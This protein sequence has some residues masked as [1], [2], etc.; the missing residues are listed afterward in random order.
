MASL[1]LLQADEAFWAGDKRAQGKLKDLI[2]G[3]EHPIEYKHIDPIWIR[4]HVRLLATSNEDFVVPAGFDER[5]F[6]MLDV[7]DAHAQDHA[8]FKAIRE[9]IDSGGRE[10][11]LQ[12]LLDFDISIVNPREIPK[13]AALVEQIIEGMSSEQAWWFDTLKN[14][15]LAWG[16]IEANTCPRGKLFVRYIKHAQ[17]QGTRRRSIETK[18]GM[19]LV[20]HVGPELKTYQASYYVREYGDRVSREH[21]RVYE[22][23]PLKVCRERFARGIGQDIAWGSPDEEWGHEF[24]DDDDFIPY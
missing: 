5:R 15:K 4:N 9:Q 11:L 10:A 14:G 23:P 13:T 19:F 1:L 24:S 18:I 8:Y 12:Y 22:F 21:G 17:Q 7:G 16:M 6:A 2:T 3:N 20:K